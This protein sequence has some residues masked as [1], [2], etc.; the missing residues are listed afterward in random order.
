MR[1]RN[2]SVQSRIFQS[3]LEPSNG[4]KNLRRDVGTFSTVPEPSHRS[5]SKLLSQ[6]KIKIVICGF[7]TLKLPWS[8][9][10]TMVVLRKTLA[11]M[12]IAGYAVEA[13]VEQPATNLQHA[14]VA[15]CALFK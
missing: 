15:N 8:T 10:V 9:M 13:A 6:K 14:F 4:F 5:F 2:D 1:D 7:S 3:H 11:T 12:N